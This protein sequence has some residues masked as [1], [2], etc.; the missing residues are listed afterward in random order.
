MWRSLMSKY[1][2]G[3]YQDE[4]LYSRRDMNEI[5]KPSVYTSD[6]IVEDNY[7]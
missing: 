2:Q 4:Q 1:E 5:V 3:H 6:V 7:F